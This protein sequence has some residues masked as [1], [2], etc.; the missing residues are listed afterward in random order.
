MAASNVD[1][2][3]AQHETFNNRD[4]DRMRNLFASDCVFVDA[5]G[6][7]HEGPEGFIEGYSKGWANAFSGGKITEAKYHD[8]GNT[9]IAEFVGKGINDGPLGPMPAS[10]REAAVPYC[11]V[12]EFDAQ[13]K[14][15]G[16]RAYFDQFGLMV[17]LGHA[18]PPP[19]A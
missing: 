14:I 2:V 9:V 11:E 7:R 16:G 6:Q 19:D 10:N 15:T 1:A 12:Y 18:E 17:Q 13:G 8:A 5:R 3:R 4:W